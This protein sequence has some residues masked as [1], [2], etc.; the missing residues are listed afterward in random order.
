MLFLVGTSLLSCSSDD[1]NDENAKHE[2]LEKRLKKVLQ[3]DID[4]GEYLEYSFF[5]NSSNKISDIHAVY[6]KYGF[7]ISR[8]EVSFLFYR[9]SI[10]IPYYEYYLDRSAYPT[11]YTTYAYHLNNGRIQKSQNGLSF[12]YSKEGRLIEVYDKGMDSGIEIK[13]TWDNKNDITQL[14]Y[15]YLNSELGRSSEERIEY[16]YTN[17]KAGM[18]GY[19]CFFNPLTE[20]NFLDCVYEHAFMWTGFCGQLSMHLPESASFYLH[21][22]DFYSKA[23]RTYE[24]EFDDLGYPTKIMINGYDYDE[25]DHSLYDYH[26]I[27]SIEWE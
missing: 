1:S 12:N 26:Y 19:F 3:T 5:Y 2:V 18:L 22:G 9:D 25:K 13:L 11:H 21:R 4:D 10:L 6:G 8:D 20:C 27:L 23:T 24:Y 16:T 15:K 14:H 17:H 7:E